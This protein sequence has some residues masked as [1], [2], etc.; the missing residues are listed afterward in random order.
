[1]Q[2]NSAWEP[3]G[4]WGQRVFIHL[5][6]QF[7]EYHRIQRFWKPGYAIYTIL[8]GKFVAAGAFQRAGQ[9]FQS[10]VE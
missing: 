2:L 6:I 3:A 5:S 4:N 1:M 9:V 7:L 8:A 10:H